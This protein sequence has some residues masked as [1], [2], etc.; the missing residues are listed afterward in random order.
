M[1]DTIVLIMI[2][3]PLIV[4]DPCGHIRP[5][6]RSPLG[7]SELAPFSLPAKK[8]PE[9]EVCIKTFVETSEVS[10]ERDTIRSTPASMKRLVP[11]AQIMRSPP[12]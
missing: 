10:S 2:D 4:G 5:S 7:F 6:R 1:P 3:A 8:R 11:L 12:N 9:K